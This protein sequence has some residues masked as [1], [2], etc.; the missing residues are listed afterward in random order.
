MLHINVITIHLF[1]NV[2][3]NVYYSIVINTNFVVPSCFM[4]RWEVVR[5]LESS[6]YIWWQMIMLS[7]IAYAHKCIKIYKNNLWNYDFIRHHG[8][9]MSFLTRLWIQI[10]NIILDLR[11][12]TITIWLIT[13]QILPS[14]RQWFHDRISVWAAQSAVTRKDWEFPQI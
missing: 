2:N 14:E 3:T 7:H 6:K 8:I 12:K 4:V 1:I 13:F 9:N 10:S 5:L 11:F